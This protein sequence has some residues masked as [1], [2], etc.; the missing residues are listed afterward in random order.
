MP[1]PLA[2]GIIIA[3]SVLVA[4]GIAIYESPQVR[5]W[6]DQSRRK[7]AVALNSLGE[8]PKP[9]RRSESSDIYA[10]RTRREELVRKN[11]NDFIK[12]AREDGIAVDL[13][14]LAKIGS[15]NIEMAERRSRSDRTKSFDDLVGSDG[16]LRA[17]GKDTSHSGLKKRGAAGFAAGSAAAAALANP[18]SDDNILFDVGDDEDDEAPSPKPFT[19][20]ENDTRESSA[21]IKPDSS[22]VVPVDESTATI[23][24]NTVSPATT[25]NDAIS[26]STP[27]I[28]LSPETHPETHSET[29][30]ET[31]QAAP[32]PYTEVADDAD[33]AAQ[34]FYSF[35]SSA[36]HTEDLAQTQFFDDEAEHV[37]T[38]TLTPRSQRSNSSAPSFVNA[39]ADDIA[40]L[41]MQTD[42]DHDARSEV[43]SEGGWTDAGLSEADDRTG[44]MTPNSWTDVGSDDE[45]EWGGQ[46]HQ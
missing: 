45:S 13:D 14:E 4:A 31:E 16:M 2:K 40:V 36:S 41:S 42:A 30:S 18:F 29:H 25:S 39:H 24:A 33:A 19:Y 12:K 26:L 10:A 46:V 20:S 37:S 6:V 5:Q 11:R 1:A 27:L 32:V 38:G 3:A 7:I 8:D 15:E 21:T 22:P 44:V 23:S 9:R 34:S 17:T 43:F 28:D 35:T